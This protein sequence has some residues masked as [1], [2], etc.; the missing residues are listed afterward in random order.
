M[1]GSQAQLIPGDLTVMLGADCDPD[2]NGHRR[3][4]GW[5]TGS[6]PYPGH[7]PV[8]LAL[9]GLPTMCWGPPY[10]MAMR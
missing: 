8:T 2:V 9:K 7:S 10:L 6:F 4:P 5:T 1:P 3:H